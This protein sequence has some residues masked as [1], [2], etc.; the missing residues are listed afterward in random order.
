MVMYEIDTYINSSDWL[1][2]T[3]D[4]VLFKLSDISHVMNTGQEIA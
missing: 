3:F 2:G 4:S 1:K